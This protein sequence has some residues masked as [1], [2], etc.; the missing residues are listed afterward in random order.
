MLSIDTDRLRPAAV[1]VV[2]LLGISMMLSLAYS[3]LVMR[4]ISVWFLFW[5]GIF[6]TL[7][8]VLAAL[9]VLY[10]LWRAVRALERI[11]TALED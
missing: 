1:A 7:V 11:A 9:A 10:L 6:G 5:S 8:G 4:S 3:V 2:V